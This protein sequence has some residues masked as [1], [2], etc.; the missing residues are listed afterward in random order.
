MP[1][2]VATF[3]FEGALRTVREIQGMLR[4][5]M[6]DESLRRRLK[7]GKRTIAEV[8]APLPKRVNAAWNARH[9]PEAKGARP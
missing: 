1:K 7:A 8:E 3:E 4:V 9:R 6:D 5:R 2:E